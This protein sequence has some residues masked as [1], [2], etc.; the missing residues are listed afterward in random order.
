MVLVRS[1][2]LLEFVQNI[3]FTRGQPVR[4]ESDLSGASRSGESGN[5]RMVPNLAG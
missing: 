4:R 1:K 3:D 5:R 2:R